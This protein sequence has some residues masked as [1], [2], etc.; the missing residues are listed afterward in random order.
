M[1][2]ILTILAFVLIANLKTANA[3]GVPDTLAYLNSIVLNKNNYIGQPFSV[4]SNNL[5]IQIKFFSPFA[6]IHHKKNME[7]ST[8]FAFYFPLNENQIYLTYPSL[9][10]YW[11]PYLNASQ[12]SIL[13]SQFDG[14]GWS[15]AVYDFYKNAIIADIIVR[16]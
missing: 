3:Q 8:S 12:S 13:Y 15:S 9:E 16:N 1:K 10:I 14:G 4:L 7:T 5:Q 6:A 2:K 11:Q